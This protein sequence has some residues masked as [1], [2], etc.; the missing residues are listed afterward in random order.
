MNICDETFTE[1]ISEKHR[2]YGIQRILELVSLRKYKDETFFKAFGI[3][4]R[5]I[6]HLG[7]E[8]FNKNL[9]VALITTSIFLAAKI[10]EPFQPSI[11]NLIDCLTEREKKHISRDLVRALE[12][13]VLVVLGF[14]LHFPGPIESM[15][16]YLRI[17]DYDLNK[18]VYA[19]ALE[20]CKF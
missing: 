17:L 14:D 18:K 11:G 5:F 13:K 7:I 2:S 4:D 1:H 9:L 20:L 8:R 10:E 3:F 12:E 16:R 6:Y 19:I 15:E